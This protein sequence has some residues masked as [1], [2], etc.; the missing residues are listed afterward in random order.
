MRWAIG[1]IVTFAGLMSVSPVAASASATINP[2]TVDFG[3]VPFDG[4]CMTVADVPND[5]CVTRTITI[6]NTGTESLEGVGFRSC[7]TYVPEFNSCFTIHA[8]WGG[9]TSGGD[10]QTCIFGVVL[11]GETCTVV[12]VADPSRRGR[13]TGSFVAEMWSRESNVTTILVVSVKLL[14]VP[15]TVR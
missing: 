11:P 8:N 6:T 15:P 7:E 10:P 14:S 5:N 12:L 1:L 13:I 9:F 4:G 3:R 2:T